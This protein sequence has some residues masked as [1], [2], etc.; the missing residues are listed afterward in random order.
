MPTY[1]GLFKLT[2]QGI[3][4]IAKAPARIEDAAKLYQKMGGKVIGTYMVMGEYDYVAIGE[5]PSDEIQAAYALTLSLQGNVKTTTL[6]AFPANEIQA[7]LNK[8]PKL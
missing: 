5:C 7:I 6:K 3:K 4:D 2:D 1:I 8:M